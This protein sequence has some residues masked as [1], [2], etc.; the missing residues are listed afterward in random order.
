ML[1][2]RGKALSSQQKEKT[3]R[4]K[5]T[6][7]PLFLKILLEVKIF[8]SYTILFRESFAFNYYLLQ[9][10][11][12]GSS[13]RMRH[14]KYWTSSIAW[15]YLGNIVEKRLENPISIVW[16]CF[17][18]YGNILEIKFPCSGRGAVFPGTQ[19]SYK[20]I[21]QNVKFVARKECHFGLVFSS[22]ICS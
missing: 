12:H 9:T 6:E 1:K 11:A 10:N 7:N 2:L 13:Q 5:Q 20:I 21:P 17:P 14:C 4:K 16:K 15:K 18:W 22:S 3:M 8:Y 19:R